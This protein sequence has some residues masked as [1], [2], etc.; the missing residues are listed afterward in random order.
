M[1]STYLLR[2]A[3]WLKHSRKYQSLKNFFHDLIDNPNSSQKTPFDLFM[4]FMVIT[5]VFLLIYQVRQPLPLWAEYFEIL[6]VFFFALEYLLRLWLV[7]DMHNVFIEHQEK[8]Q[9]TGRKF[10][11]GKALREALA[12]KFRYMRTPFAIIDLLAI[13]P[14]YR[15]LRILRIFLLFR[16]FKLFRYANSIQQFSRVLAEKRVEFLTLLMFMGFVLF[17][18]SSAIYVLETNVEGSAI[19]SYFDAFYWAL[20]TIST[21]GY[22]DITPVSREGQF[23][24]I[25]LILAGIG[26][27]SFFTSI[28]VS[29]FGEKMKLVRVNQ[30]IKDA[31][32]R[33]AEILI[34]GYGRVGKVVAQSL[35]DA[36]K[37]AVIIE[38]NEFR[39]EQAK[40]DGYIVVI[41]DASDDALLMKLGVNKKIR[42]SA[43]NRTEV[44][45]YVSHVLCLTGS[46]STNAYIAL[47]TRQLD[48]ELTILARLI[49]PK[50]ER[51][52]RLA[53][54]D[55]VVA[56]RE[57][58]G[59]MAAKYISAPIVF[60]ALTDMLNQNTD[61][62]IESVFLGE[63]S[64][65]T[66]KSVS[67]LNLDKYRLE[68]IGI[69]RNRDSIDHEKFVNLNETYDFCFKPSADFNFQNLDVLIVLGH[70]Y[71]IEHLQDD[72]LNNV[73]GVTQ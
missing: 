24:T 39:A 12:V 43:K 67:S 8:A 4:V 32:R 49:E 30:Y 44:S 72:I 42:S 37:L 69:I 51:R 18:A 56:S 3:L 47:T 6:A 64:G 34:C 20:V 38:K 66:A 48:K 50:N 9:Y 35:Q 23:V 33:R 2:L 1:V 55:N 53:G 19:Q 16:V 70:R 11:A 31:Q 52:L 28:I 63:N 15:P 61:I 68:L 65:L 13:L 58:A 36:N 22:G 46:D 25:L 27:I 57:I 54:V 10:K 7:S 73:L 40:N 21:V 62:Q 5:S 45:G 26:V 60:E 71:G 14:A 59:L 29:S 17:S 41:G